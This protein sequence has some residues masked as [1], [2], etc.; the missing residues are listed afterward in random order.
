MRPIDYGPIETARSSWI[1]AWERARLP[2]RTSSIRP[3]NH[4]FQTLLPPMRRTP[5]VTAMLPVTAV[6]RPA[7]VDVEPERGAVV[8]RGHVRPRVQGQRPG[9]PDGP[10]PAGPDLRDWPRISL[11]RVQRVRERAALLEDHRSPA[12]PEGRRTHPRRERHP[13]RQVEVVRVG[14]RHPVV[15]AVE[16]ERAAEPPSRRPGR[17][18]DRARVPVPRRVGRDAPRALVERVRGHEP[19]R[20]RRRGVVD[21]DVHDSSRARAAGRVARLC[22]EL[23]EAEESLRS[24]STRPS[25]A[26]TCPRRLEAGRRA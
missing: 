3:A 18:R 8:G 24:C 16:G 7:P 11:V 26:R 9:P 20:K 25:R 14:D 10:E 5:D 6:G 15:H 4:S 19:V 2:T 17:T 23:V 22:R 13:G 12:T 21:S 1:S